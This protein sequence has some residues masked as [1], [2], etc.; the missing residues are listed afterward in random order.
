VE[1]PTLVVGVDVVELEVVVLEVVEVVVV[2]VLVTVAGSKPPVMV[3]MAT[4]HAGPLIQAPSAKRLV[5]VD[6]VVT[7]VGTT[8]LVRFQLVALPVS[9]R[10]SVTA[11]CSPVTGVALLS[12][13]DEAISGPPL[14]MVDALTA[15]VLVPA[16]MVAGV[17]VPLAA[18]VMPPVPVAVTAPPKLLLVLASV[19]EPLPACR[20]V[21]PLTSSAPVCVIS[22]LVVSE[23]LPV[24]LVP[25]V[26]EEL[27]T[28]TT[29]PVVFT[30]TVP[31]FAVPCVTEMA[32]PLLVV[33]E[34]LPPTVR[35]SVGWSRNVMLVPVNDASLVT[36]WLVPASEIGPAAAKTRLPAVLLPV[37]TIAESSEMATAPGEL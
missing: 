25:S 1:K 20:L 3:V 4:P 9:V 37:M 29:E 26:V 11:V 21:V 33:N 18:S 12:V 14:P 13:A 17:R 34:A 36:V 2:I 32:P 24:L 5:V 23:S 8:T 19:I 31:K 6:V 27:S 15:S 7:V 35:T 16:S 22:P 30:V 28:R 10:V